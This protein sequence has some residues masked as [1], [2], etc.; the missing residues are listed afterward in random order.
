MLEIYNEKLRDLLNPRDGT[1]KP[2]EV[3]SHPKVTAAASAMVQIERGH[4]SVAAALGGSTVR[5]L[6]ILPRERQPPR[7]KATT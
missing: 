4:L 5:T 3:H 1:S 7:K 2:L 6:C